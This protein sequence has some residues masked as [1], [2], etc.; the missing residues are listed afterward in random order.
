MRSD[1]LV[2][3]KPA[4]LVRW[5][6]RLA[7]I[8]VISSI[9]ILALLG[10][11]AL[12]V[13]RPEAVRDRRAQLAP[14]LA[15]ESFAEAFTRAYLTW[16]PTRPERHERQVA[17]FAS[18]S[19]GPSAGLSVP[20]GRRQQVTW[21]ATAKD[22]AA[23]RTEH[24]ITVAAGTS[25]GVPYY[26]SV[27]V[28]RDR[29]GLLAISGYPALLGPP[30]VDTRMSPVDEAEVEDAGLRTVARRAIANYL[31]REG[32]N[33]RAD[34]DSRAVVALPVTPL[35]IASVDSIT[36]VRPGRIA[37]ELRAG[38]GGATWTLR[39]ELDVVKRDRWYV[40]SIQT[41]QA[42]RSSQ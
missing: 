37:L 19:L 16:D 24:L 42:G 21:T 26:V 2:V 15:A 14:D 28:G 8:A 29:R 7:R 41:N 33:L 4:W 35:R 3:T 11:L 39:Y 25:S 10:L 27:P 1:V 30:P 5:S 17:S 23:S 22:E 40:R 6:G 9:G 34:L 18:E 31:R 38:G 32:T 20:A 13:G 36:R 12:F